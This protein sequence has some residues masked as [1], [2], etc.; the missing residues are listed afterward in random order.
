[1]GP[2]TKGG[3]VINK[4]PNVSGQDAA[5]NHSGVIQFGSQWYIVYH[6]S[7]GPNGGGTYQRE[8]QLDKLNFNADGT[9]QNINASTSK[10]ITF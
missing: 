5:T 10:V 1:M 2:W 8:V 6:V 3:I 9:I 7:D 4:L